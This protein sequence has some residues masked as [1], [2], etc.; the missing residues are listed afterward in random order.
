V[1]SA[2]KI[3]PSWKKY[4]TV[5]IGSATKKQIESL[6]GSVI[7]CPSSFYGKTLSQDIVK[8][9][10][11]KKLLYLRPKKVSFDTKSYLENTGVELKEQVI[12]E[13]SCIT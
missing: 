4:P 7:Y 9:F 13:T 1:K 2:E 8:Y 3:D 5:A 11:E 6:G 10:K 12:Y